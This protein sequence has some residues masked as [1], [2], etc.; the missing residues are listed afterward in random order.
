M[1][2]AQRNIEA[3][4]QQLGLFRKEHYDLKKEI[5]LLQNTVSSLSLIISNLQT[6]INFIRSQRGTGP[7]SFS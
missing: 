6:T 5:Q 3:F 7:S 2:I 1:N 4:T